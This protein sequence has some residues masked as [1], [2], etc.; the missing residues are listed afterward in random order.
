MA[1][2]DKALG[3]SLSNVFA[4]TAKK[5]PSVGGRGFLE[6]DLNLIMP[7]DN[8]PRTHFGDEA[9]AELAAS[10][11]KHGILQPIVVAKR[12]GGYEIIAGERRWRA[13]KQLAL[14]KVPVV[15]RAKGEPHEV[16][17]L[18]LIENI[19]REDLNP[20]ELALAYRALLTDFE[21][22]QEQV[23][24]EVGKDRSSVANSLRL[25]T[26]P[27]A[28]Q[29]LLGDGQLSMGHARALITLGNDRLALAL[30]RRAIE[31][32]LSVRA[33][34]R[35]AREA[36]AGDTSRTEKPSAKKDKPPHIRELEGN[37]SR[38]FD[39]E[40]AVKER[41]GKGS[42]TVRFH[43]KGHFKAVLQQLES[44]FADSRKQEAESGAE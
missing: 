9:L 29:N 3:K 11:S 42:L 14:A 17:Q 38:L 25:L 39:A 23:A 27:P 26:L 40:V 31:E 21:L 24:E 5:E 34:E 28:I 8:N 30:A 16:A 37:L 1:L 22:T 33:V 10:I 41:G 44:A 32:G 2:N 18:R 12:E 15:V 7:P 43:S 6:V 19:Q 35:L 36:A 13:A 4:R 20:I